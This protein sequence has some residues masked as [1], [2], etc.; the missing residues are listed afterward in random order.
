MNKKFFVL[1][2]AAL[3]GGA[4]VALTAF[5]GV[6]KAMQLAQIEETVQAQLAILRETKTKECDDSVTQAAGVKAQE[7]LAAPVAQQLTAVPGKPGA[8]K[9]TKKPTKGGSTKPGVDPL[10]Q[11]APPAKPSVPGSQ[12]KWEKAGEAK[13]TQESQTKW[14]KPADPNA[15]AVDPAAKPASKSK[16][17]KKEGG[18]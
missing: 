15:K 13:P 10:P 3:V 11:P 5:G 14:S 4:F 16:W 2:G 1:G 17:E 18:N 7:M 6:T 12:S 8:T 9:P